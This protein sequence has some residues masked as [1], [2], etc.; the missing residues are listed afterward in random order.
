M[1]TL[2]PTTGTLRKDGVVIPNDDS[3][4]EYQAYVA[5]LAQGNGPSMIHGEPAYPRIEVS[6]WQLVQALD[7]KGLLE[8]VDSIA[9]SHPSPLVRIGWK[10]APTFWSDQPLTL[11][12]APLIPLTRAEMQAVFELADTL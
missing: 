7:R 5:W 4:L 9:E 3:T 6:A 11:G 8:K 2:D 12:L 10:K 1:Y